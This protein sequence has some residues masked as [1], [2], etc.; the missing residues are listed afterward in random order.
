MSFFIMNSKKVNGDLINFELIYNSVKL[1]FDNYINY[2]VYLVGMSVDEFLIYKKELKNILEC[3][4][5]LFLN[6][7]YDINDD[8]DDFIIKFYDNVI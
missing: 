7:K 3:I 4:N 5:I 2:W 6:F 1:V 8:I